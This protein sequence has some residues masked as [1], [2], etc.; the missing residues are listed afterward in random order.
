MYDELKDLIDR[1]VN[2][3]G[4]WPDF[5]AFLEKQGYSLFEF[6]FDEE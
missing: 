1:F 5:V 2:E 3:K 6:G 4:L